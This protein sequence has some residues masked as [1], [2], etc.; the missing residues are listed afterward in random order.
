MVP[1]RF[2]KI[3]KNW[4]WNFE[5][6]WVFRGG[7]PNWRVFCVVTKCIVMKI[8]HSTLFCVAERTIWSSG[9]KGIF[10]FVL[11]QE[12]L[13]DEATRTSSA[14]WCQHKFLMKGTQRGKQIKLSFIDTNINESCLYVPW[15]SFSKIYL[16]NLQ[17][18]LFIRIPTH[19][20]VSN[21][22]TIIPAVVP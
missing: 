16:T 6:R 13:M 3:L 4:A 14:F 21:I 12:G 9:W 8:E 11:W 1:N 5:N 7:A 18:H 15:I 17:T 19:N 20:F 2:A 10:C 22:F